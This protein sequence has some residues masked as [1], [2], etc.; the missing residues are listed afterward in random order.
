MNRT[1]LEYLASPA[2][3][4]RLESDLIPWIERVATLGDDVLE[5]GPGPGLTTDILCK[6]TSHVTAVE[7]D[8]DLADAL[9]ART[10]G[11]NVEVHAGDA[12]MLPFESDRFTAATCFS[13]LHHV[14]TSEHQDRVLAELLRVLRPGA[15]LFATDA[16]DTPRIRDAHD[17]DVFVPMPPESLVARLEQIG[18]TDVDVELADYELRL[19]ARKPAS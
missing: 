12:A 7:I 4:E 2:W 10:A 17:D 16:R 8:N 18:F 14:P 1:H 5:V 19:A 13:V 6:R 15:G 11:T 9:Q 3:A